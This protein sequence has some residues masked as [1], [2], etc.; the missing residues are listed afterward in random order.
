M[1]SPW[2]VAPTHTGALR[3]RGSVSPPMQRFPNTTAEKSTAAEPLTRAQ[4]TSCH[5]YQN[6]MPI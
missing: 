3:V 5:T 2:H 4:A 1:P 6:A